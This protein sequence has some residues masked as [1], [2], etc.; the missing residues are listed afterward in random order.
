MITTLK[1]E[2]ILRF[3]AVGSGADGC[4]GISGGGGGGEGEERVE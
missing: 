2:N 4:S 1:A 3:F